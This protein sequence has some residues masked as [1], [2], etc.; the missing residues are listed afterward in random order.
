[1]TNSS[2]NAMTDRPSSPDRPALLGGRPVRPAGP[3][4]WPL[5]DNAV[6]EA[7]RRAFIDGSWGKY[8]GP[9]GRELA[10]RLAEMH[11]SKHVLLTSSGTAAVELALRGLRISAGDEVILSAYDFAGNFKNVLTVGARPVLVDVDSATGQLDVTQLEA[12][13][14]PQTKA[15]IVSHLHGGLVDMPAVRAFADRHRLAVIEDACQLPGAI[16]DG[17]VAGTWGDVGILSFGGS[18]L[19]TAG[20]G[21]ALFT[22]SSA[23]AQRSRLYTQ[24]GN[25]AYP[26][27]ELQA[28]V[29]IPQLDRLAERN[30][31]RAA[32]VARL[33]SSLRDVT[34]LRCFV[35]PDVSPLSKGGPEGVKAPG[36]Y[37][38]GFSYDSASFGDVPRDR[39][40]CAM[41][42][43][44]IAFDPGFRALHLTHARGRFHAIGDLPQATRA[45]ESVLVLH[46]PVLLGQDDDLRQIA[47]AVLKLQ[48]HAGELGRMTP[49]GS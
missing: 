20:R 41:R 26:L 6:S 48:G 31:L 23:I 22:N 36:F 45:G 9:N 32:N 4:T 29:L 19:L 2:D 14:S 49:N 46:H 21:G 28:A 27:S 42:A 43:E 1:M 38:L 30:D 40:A 39:F 7:L 25:D 35:D 47:D 15:L 17:R 34:G 8:H 44:G 3:P 10:E 12:A 24:R 13:R 33:L 16:V 11:G 5:A 37:K 18:K